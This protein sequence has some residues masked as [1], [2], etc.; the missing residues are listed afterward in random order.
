MTAADVLLSYQHQMQQL[1]ATLAALHSRQWLTLG[2]GVAALA[3]T[4]SLAISRRLPHS[5]IPL[6]IVAFCA[7]R[8]GR[9]QSRRSTLSRL[10][11]FYE[12]G[13]ARLQ[14]QWAGNGESGDEYERPGHLYARD[15]N[16][17]GR[18]S[19]FERLCLARTE[20]GKSKLAAY[21]QDPCPPIAEIDAR[22]AAVAELRDNTA[23][24]EQ[25]ATL[26]EAYQQAEATTFSDWLAR[27]VRPFPVYLR[28]LAALTSLLAATALCL[29]IGGQLSQPILFSVLAIQAAIAWALRPRVGPIIQ[30]SRLLAVELALVRNGVSLLARQNFHSPKLRALTAAT[31]QAPRH[32]RRLGF[33]LRLL[34]E[35]HKEHFY[36]PA[37]VIILGTQTAMAIEAWRDQHGAAMAAWLDA[38]AEFETLNALACY[39]YENPEDPFPSIVSGAPVFDAAALGHPLLPRHACVRNDLRLPRLLLLSGS[40]MA[41]KSTLLRA[42]G[43]NAVLAAAGAPVR[44]ASLCLSPFSLVAS[45]SIQDALADGKSRFLAEV[46]RLRHALHLAA[47]S[48]PVLF[49]IDEIFSGTNSTDRRIA[50]EAVAAALGE[51]GAVG[52][53]STHDLALTAI[54]NSTNVHMCAR[55][56][57][58]PLDFDYV[59]K[60][61]INTQSNALAIA[62]LAG[63]PV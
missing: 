16:L 13:V 53:I 9:Q 46:E 40:N 37:S 47:T 54:P 21:L 39:A 6:P 4:L 56:A 18:G 42:I 48:P 49:L 14:D 2:I 20:I 1:Q 17:F 61:G 30:N 44:A 59:L 60:P 34:T 25:L 36:M 24:R 55:S 33:L 23:L 28:I 22:Q 3:L 8:Y 41:G 10:R 27:P 15:L 63:V 31:R 50:A 58:D 51:S 11:A 43:V 35:R 38:W 29:A 26:G 62:R 19:L 32:L 57:A 7:H 45:L 5:P 52:A 12:S